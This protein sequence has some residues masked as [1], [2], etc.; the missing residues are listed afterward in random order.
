MWAPVE[1][2]K[3]LLEAHPKAASVTNNFGNLALHFTAWKKGPLECMS[4]AGNC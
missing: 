1:V 4:C 2:V 3:A